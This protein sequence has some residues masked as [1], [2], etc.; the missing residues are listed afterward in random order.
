[1][2]TENLIRQKLILVGSHQAGKSSLLRTMTSGQ[3]KVTSALDDSTP[4]IDF[5]AWTTKNKV[6]FLVCDTSGDDVYSHTLHL[7]V[8]PNAL[9]VIVYDHRS[10]TPKK[11]DDTIGRWLDFIYLHAPGAVVKIVGT[12][13]DLAY[14][15]IN[16]QVLEQV[17]ENVRQQLTSYGVNIRDELARINTAIENKDGRQP[18]LDRQEV[19]LL[20][21]QKQRLVRLGR[22]PL[23]VH[24]EVQLLDCVQDMRGVTQLVDCFEVMAVNTNLFPLAQR[25]VPEKWLKLRS[26]LQRCRTHF[27]RLRDVEVIADVIK[28]PP[29]QLRD[30]LAH[31]HDTGDIL[32]LRAHAGL[33]DVIFP[34][35]RRLVSLLQSLFRHDMTSSLDFDRNRIFLA[36]GN[37]DRRKFETARDFF[38]TSGQIS[39]DLLKSFWFFERLDEDAF[40]EMSELVPHFNLC[41]TIP[42]SALP[43]HYHDY[44][45]LMVIPTFVGDLQPDLLPHDWSQPADEHL[46]ELRITFTFLLFLPLGLFERVS[47]RLQ[48]QV[49]ERTDW[50]DVIAAETEQSQVLVT[51]GLDA[52]TYDF[53]LTVAVRGPRLEGVRQDLANIYTELRSLVAHYPGLVWRVRLDSHNCDKYF[54]QDLFPSVIFAESTTADVTA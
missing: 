16:E 1:M 11:H 14:P 42:Q 4:M 17:R 27:V 3:S 39:R 19:E 48:E 15:E 38:V 8:D 43:L 41:Y 34:R 54:K 26:Q 6:S 21:R 9:Y 10:Y 45:P 25:A 24:H 29:S 5:R 2:K 47:C 36:R 30:C 46:L 51:R 35:P 40:E 50:R 44:Q 28:L 18:V 23:R 33:A 37:M 31:L 52:E 22:T 20:R 32:W 49:L 12:Q 7:F 13:C 53:V